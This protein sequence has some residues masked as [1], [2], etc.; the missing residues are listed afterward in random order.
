[1]SL[2]KVPLLLG[3]TWWHT[4]DPGAGAH[5]LNEVATPL[6]TPH[7]KRTREAR[8]SWGFGDFTRQQTWPHTADPGT[9]GLNSM[10]WSHH[11]SRH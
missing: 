4:V 7:T 11:W 2:T 5:E 8:I 6:V 9:D 10:K 3:Q 1:M